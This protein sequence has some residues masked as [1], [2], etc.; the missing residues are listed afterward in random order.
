MLILPAT[1]TLDSKQYHPFGFE[2]LMVF[3]PITFTAE[4]TRTSAGW[5]VGLSLAELLP[6]APKTVTPGAITELADVP[7]VKGEMMPHDEMQA[8]RIA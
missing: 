8:S 6:P 5:S 7:F 3:L 1:V 4:R 2:S